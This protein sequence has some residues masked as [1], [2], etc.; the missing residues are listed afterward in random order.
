MINYLKQEG[1]DFF[2]NKKNIVLYLIVGFLSLFFVI[3]VEPNFKIYETTNLKK[4]EA[5]YLDKKHFLETVNLEGETHPDTLSAVESFRMV[6][7][8]EEKRYEALKKQDFKIYAKA[9]AEWYEGGSIL[10]PLYYTYGNDFAEFENFYGNRSMGP[11]MV[12][13]AKQTSKL[14]LNQLNE[15]TAWQV[16]SRL[17]HRILPVLFSLLA[18]LFS[19]DMISKDRQHKSLVNGYPLSVFKR[20]IAKL[21]ITFIGLFL[22]IIP[23]SIGFIWIGL[24]R[25]FGL[26]SLP[27][28]YSIF[29]ID[30]VSNLN[31]TFSSETIGL[32]LAKSLGLMGLS[33]LAIVLF[34]FLISFWLKQDFINL[35]VIV[36]I[37]FSSLFYQ[38]HGLGDIYALYYSPTSYLYSGDIVSGYQGFFWSTPYLTTNQGYLVVG[39]TVLLL[40]LLLKLSTVKKRQL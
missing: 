23:L 8:I 21:I 16:V 26:L 27:S 1:Q 11:K 5:N 12:Q 13:Y 14:S 39:V 10:N 20:L 17:M 33:C 3:Q 25:G 36:L 6:L 35:V 9:T 22:M 15:E 38:R 4:I 18:I 32:F 34:T 30:A 37:T 19:V 31:S 24:R 7:P 40:I 2:H 28:S 29:P